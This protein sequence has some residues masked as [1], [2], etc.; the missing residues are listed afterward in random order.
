MKRVLVTGC[1]DPLHS[2]HIWFLDRAAAYGEL[3]VGVGSD[4]T[5]RLLKGEPRFPQEERL[6]VVSSLFNVKRAFISP[7]TGR[8][9]FEPEMSMIEPDYLIVNED[10]DCI[11]KARL[12][13]RL[14]CIYVVLQRT[15]RPGL[16]ERTSTD[17]ITMG[18]R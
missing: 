4:R 13:E 1:F 11:E 18:C 16:P 7:G 10:G 14:G 8:L 15:P 12:C 17:I 3:Y 6:Y 9:D 5:I 2:G